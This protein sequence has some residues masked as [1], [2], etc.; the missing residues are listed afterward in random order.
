MRLLRTVL[1]LFAVSTFSLSAAVANSISGYLTADN[2]FNAYLSTSPTTQGTPITSGNNWQ[3]SY[4]LSV[5][6]TPGTTY[7]LQIEGIN[8][9]SYS[10]NNP[11]VILGSFSISGSFLFSNGT[12]SLITDTTDWTYSTTGFGSAAYTPASYGTNNQSTT[13]WYKAHGGPIANI[14]GTAQW[15]WYQ[16]NPAYLATPLY[17]ETKISPTP[18]PGSFLLLASGLASALGMWRRRLAG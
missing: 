5:S 9:G 7:Y 13:I 1:L 18:E 3:T 2:Q 10:T 14:A 17:F 8:T 11:G 6:L 16:S 12:Q 4:P 15:I